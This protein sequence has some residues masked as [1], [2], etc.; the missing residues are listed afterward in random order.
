MDTC[1]YVRM[2]CGFITKPADHKN[3][4]D[5]F[6]TVLIVGIN[7]FLI[8]FLM[9]ILQ[10]MVLRQFIKIP[11]TWIT[12]TIFGCLFAEI[13]GVVFAVGF[14]LSMLYLYGERL[15]GWEFMQT[16]FDLVFG[17][18]F[19]GLFQS[20][21]LSRSLSKIG[22]RIGLLWV[23]GVWLGIGLGVLL[24]VML[25]ITCQTPPFQIFYFCSWGE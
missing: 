17:G 14:P 13:F 25:I 22:N 21:V 19:V 4:S 20:I 7:G 9:G 2:E 8:G 23:I 1:H 6:Q 3:Q 5:F 18:F 24:P 11:K 12:A 16:P 15:S 10:W